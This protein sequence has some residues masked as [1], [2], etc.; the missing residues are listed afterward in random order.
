[1][2]RVTW[3]TIRDQLPSTERGIHLDHAS[4][5]PVSRRVA[6]AMR[7][8]VDTYEADGY[9]PA[10]RDDADGVR[11]SIARLV[12]SSA[13]RIAFTQN[14]ST[15]LSLAANGV[16]WHPGDNVVLPEHEFPSNR[17]PWLNLSHRGVEVRRVPA[18]A[19]H[20]T[21]GAIRDAID[22]RTRVVTISSVQY[23][24]GHR[25]D[26][27]ALGDLCRRHDVLFV[28]DGTQSVGALTIDVDASG[29]D[30]LAVSGHKWML[31]PAGAAFVHV[32]DRALERL[33]V[34]VVGWMSV[35]EP[36]AFDGRLDLPDAARRFEPGTENTAGI[37]GL[38]AATDLFLELD[39]T[40][41]EDRVLAVTDHLCDRLRQRGDAV[42]SPRRGPERSGIVI[43]VPDDR[44]P[45]EVHARLA[46]AGVR[47]A[48]RGGGIRFSP[49][50][51]TT[52]DE[53]DRALSLI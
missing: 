18:P 43:F 39:P 28:V 35:A 23:S 27:D 16:D 33:R 49:H 10:W 5:S 52:E 47:C 3:A 53:I 41:V 36:F 7:S 50:M 1:M 2:D 38:G 34:D 12:G 20:A 46:G 4:I 22:A 21:I 26:L 30:L 14:T 11:E 17:Y 6:E 25:Y 40:M 42:L 45:E 29:I 48:P 9:Q 44:D 32:S 31:G 15:G 51:Y 19:G 13:R 37:M 8:V 24:T